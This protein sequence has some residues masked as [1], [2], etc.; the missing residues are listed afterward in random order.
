MFKWTSCHEGVL[1]GGRQGGEQERGSNV[2][3]AGTHAEEIL[4]PRRSSAAKGCFLPSPL[5]CLFLG[6]TKPHVFPEHRHL[7]PPPLL[8]DRISGSPDWP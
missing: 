7:S 4:I 6:P 5:T 1:C 8:S 3:D 2:T